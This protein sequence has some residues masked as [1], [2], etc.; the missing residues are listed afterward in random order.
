MTPSVMPSQEQAAPLRPVEP[1]PLFQAQKALAVAA[2]LGCW[3]LAMRHLRELPHPLPTLAQ[4]FV[5]ARLPLL[6]LLAG[7]L[8]IVWFAYVVGRQRASERA[9]QPAATPEMRR[10]ARILRLVMLTLIAV[11]FSAPYLAFLFPEYGKSV[12]IAALLGVGFSAL[13]GRFLLK[14]SGKTR[15]SRGEYAGGIRREPLYVNTLVLVA[16]AFA[17]AIAIDV[18]AFQI[19]KRSFPAHEL[20][21]FRIVN[22]ITAALLTAAWFW[23]QRSS[24]AEPQPA[25]LEDPDGYATSE[26]RR[27]KTIQIL[28]LCGYAVAF[29]LVAVLPIRPALRHLLVYA[30]T[31]PVVVY[32]GVLRRVKA[33]IFRLGHKGETDKALRMDRFWGTL[34]LYGTSLRG[35]VL[36]NAGRYREALAFLK[37][38]AFDAQGRPRLTSVALYSYSLALVNDNRP[39]EAEP[40]LEAAIAAVP[41]PDHLKVALATCLLSQDKDPQR[42]VRLLEE[43]MASTPRGGLA[44]D[45]S[46]DHARRVA[47]YAWALSAASRTR[48][49]RTR[50][51]Q[52]IELA[53]ALRPEDAAG[54]QYFVGE[55][56]RAMGENAKA[57]AAFDEAVRLRP[58]GVTALSVKKALAKMVATGDSPA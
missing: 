43:A 50:I 24:A 29:V 52:A 6:E 47:R 56:W 9:A 34:P 2:C 17:A 16:L 51:D 36:F 35:T 53:A 23:L 22:A 42:A 3:Y 27:R 45:N 10:R 11:G 58:T 41:D 39:S 54:V 28:W 44:R 33:R 5:Q 25:A 14:P 26:G 38:L 19:A 32:A 40:L 55:A 48:D 15:I 18:A 30:E 4:R 37:P 21:I 13:A 7:V 12:A 57:R 46:A 31:L 1:P 20:V 49:A 8:C